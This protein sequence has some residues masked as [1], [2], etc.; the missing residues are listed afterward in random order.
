LYF[1][2]E[3]DYPRQL[4]WTFLQEGDDQTGFFFEGEDDCIK[5]LGQINNL[6]YNYAMEVDIVSESNMLYL[7][8]EQIVFWYLDEAVLA[9][10]MP[11]LAAGNMIIDNNYSES[12]MTGTINVP[13]GCSTVFTTIP[14]D[15]GWHVYVDGKEVELGKTLDALISFEI[16]EGTHDIE[17]RYFN[18]YLKWGIII[19]AVS[20]VLAVGVFVLDY[21]VLRKRLPEKRRRLEERLALEAKREAE[22]AAIEAAAEAANNP[23]TNSEEGSATNENSEQ[24]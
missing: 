8:Q 12:H 4:E 20:L 13:A 18:D 2:F 14:Y 16:T 7:I 15:E 21:T 24:K 6:E 9:E 10:V 5:H 3:S 22:R 19:S 1:F 17:L 23:G 11:K